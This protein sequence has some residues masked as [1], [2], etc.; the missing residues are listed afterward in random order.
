MLLT[1]ELA[2]P[3]C[4]TVGPRGPKDIPVIGA[5]IEKS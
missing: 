1:K 3:A 5:V 2:T 4:T